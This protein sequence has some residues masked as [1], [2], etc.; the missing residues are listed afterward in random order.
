MSR[1]RDLL[2]SADP[3]LLPLP[4]GVEATLAHSNSDP[5][6]F[7]H[8]FQ[9]LIDS[10]PEQIA[11]VDEDWTIVAVNRAWTKTAAAYG[12][13]SLGSGANYFNFCT[14]KAL[15]DHPSAGAVRD[16]MLDM[17]HGG[18]ESFRMVYSGTDKWAGHDF[19]LC[20]NRLQMDG[21]RFCTVTRYDVTELLKLRRLQ[22]DFSSSVLEGQAEERRRMAREIHDS[23]M[24]LLV[25][26]GL[27]IGQLK[28][29]RQAED[30]PLVLA[31]MEELLGEA[32]QEIRSISY[33]AHPP[34]L[35][36]L[37]LATSLQ[38]L[39]EGY[40]RRTDLACSFGIEGDCPGGEC[41]DIS[42]ASEV[43]IYRLIQEALLNVHRHAHATEAAVRLFFRKSM[44]HV[45]IVDNGVGVHASRHSGVGLPGMRERVAELGGRLVLRGLSPGTAVIAS[46]PRNASTRA[47]GDLAHG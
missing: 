46:L 7:I 40:G 37:G 23:T 41:R 17:M 34:T 38:I 45:V 31:E 32:Q 39:V 30:V 4:P 24:Q 11:L 12:F 13:H 15:E 26:I 10:L 5:H 27:A 14:E 29:V 44:I 9:Q 47:V 33:L 36:K 28:R 8:G 20:I 25:G 35:E 42:H 19:Q 3:A 22:E 43:A 16:G 21:H 6:E 18:R 1:E 2:M